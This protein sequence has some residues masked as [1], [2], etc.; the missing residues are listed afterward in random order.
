MLNNRAKSDNLGTESPFSDTITTGYFGLDFNN[1]EQ[2]DSETLLSIDARLQGSEMSKDERLFLNGIIR[3][4]RPQKIVEY[5][6]AAGGSAAVILNAIKDIPDAKLYSLDYSERYYQD[7]SKPVGWMIPE[8][9]PH[10]MDKWECL[11]GG[12]CC[13]F[14][15]RITNNGNDKI[16]VCLI[17]T[18]HS[19]PGEFLNILEV[20]PYMKRNSII[21]LHDT[22]MH[23]LGDMKC[24]TN[25][26]CLNTFPGK[27][28]VLLEDTSRNCPVVSNIG[29]IVLD[30][31][32]AES[33][34]YPARA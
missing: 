6:V 17:D 19:N 10:L 32:V 18:V 29:G 13:R 7:T 24:V 4:T 1:I 5:G 11:S 30:N 2:Y 16:D 33:H 20:L 8:Q 34:Y 9:F 25:C 3:K 31:N 27:R 28:I 21:V 23:T 14:L 12:V 15:D 22:A 26:I